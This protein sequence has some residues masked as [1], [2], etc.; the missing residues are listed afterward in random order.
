M[1][2]V[3]LK[4]RTSQFER[5]SNWAFPVYSAL[6]TSTV[7]AGTMTTLPFVK[8]VLDARGRQRHHG[9]MWAPDDLEIEL[10]RGTRVYAKLYAVIRV[11]GAVMLECRS[12]HKYIS[13]CNVSGATKTHTAACPGP[14]AAA[15]AEPA[16]EMVNLVEPVEEEALRGVR[17]ITSYLV[18]PV[19]CQLAHI[20]STPVL[21]YPL[22]IICRSVRLTTLHILA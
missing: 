15:D 5:Q 16:I 18:R 2:K 6:A 10:N 12:C 13:P 7:H 14:R 1:Y 21:S 3:G 17:P 19:T 8:I 9:Q 20:C 4:A 11:G 22:S